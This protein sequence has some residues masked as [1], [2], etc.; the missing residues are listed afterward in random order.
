MS[1]RLP[2]KIKD[3]LDENSIDLAAK[4]AKGVLGIAP[5]IGTTAAELVGYIIPNLRE[6]RMVDFLRKLTIR[7]NDLEDF[8]RR[9]NEPENIDLTEEAL[10]QAS[11]ASTEERREYLANLLKNS[12][13]KHEI[14]HSEKK[15]LFYL[16]DQLNDQ[17]VILLKFYS[18]GIRTQQDHPFKEKHKDIIIPPSDYTQDM[19]NKA[20]FFYT[21]I[22]TLDTL[23]LV[24][25][26]GSKD[27]KRIP[28]IVTPMGAL[29]LEYIEVP[30]E[31]VHD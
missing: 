28:E 14:E 12:L 20:S 19:I 22:N 27:F 16:L 17:E 3:D 13:T 5:G 7:V 4:L 6:D 18:L 10:I 11:R 21:Y 30:D 23:G 2:S 15:K 25:K 26:Q 29:L 9:M 24:D 31:E 1:G 8:I